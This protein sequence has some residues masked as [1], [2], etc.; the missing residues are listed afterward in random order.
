[1]FVLSW[2]VHGL[3]CNKCLGISIGIPLGFFF[4]GGQMYQ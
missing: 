2:C 3:V 1:M 4:I